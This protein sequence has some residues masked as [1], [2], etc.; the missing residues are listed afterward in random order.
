MTAENHPYLAESDGYLYLTPAGGLYATYD[1]T[2][3][4]TRDFLLRLMAQK[5][6]PGIST[7]N[8]KELTRLDDKSSATFLFQL[9]SAAYIQRVEV[10]VLAPPSNVDR[11]HFYPILAKLSDEE[12][13]SLL[14]DKG[15]IVCSV[16]HS[17]ALAKELAGFTA[18]VLRLKEKS[19]ALATYLPDLA[20][21]GFSLANWRG[22][23]ELTIWPL[24]W[25]SHRYTLAIS[26]L[27]R[28]NSNAFVALLYALTQQI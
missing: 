26:G 9:Q 5:S 2:S 3:N 14:T 19:R 16:G 15:E 11:S 12:K 1:G 6:S 20:G 22:Y 13:V 28:F 10:P 23:S 7:A 21:S 27:P 8:L 17:E 24:Y 4:G 18:E 25:H